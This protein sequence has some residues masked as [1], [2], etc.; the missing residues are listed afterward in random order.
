MSNTWFQFK[1]FGIEQDRCGMKVSTDA[2]ILGAWAPIAADFRR[3]LDIGTGTGLLALMLAQRGVQLKIDAL[4]LN[5]AAAEQ[6]RENVGR[7]PFVGQVMVHNT[8]VFQ[9]Q[10]MAKYDMII[11]NPPFFQNSLKGPD[12][13]RNAARHADTLS[14]LGLASIIKEHLAPDGLACVLWPVKEHELF[15]QAAF[16]LGLFLQKQLHI[17]DRDRN[18]VGRIIGCF[19][20]RFHAEIV[21]EHL[22]IKTETGAY[23]SAFQ[24]LL[25][26]FYLKL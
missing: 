15:K 7:S 2:C 11:C 23:T 8:D 22:V 26:A 9:W 19:G 3:A 4:E 13:A 24:E 14:P 18:K 17:C 21:T 10:F 16:S 12:D 1:E 25:Q 6:A 5:D 20:S